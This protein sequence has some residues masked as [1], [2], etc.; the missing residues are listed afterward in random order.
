MNAGLLGFWLGGIVACV[1]YWNIESV[2]WPDHRYLWL[3]RNFPVVMVPLTVLAMVFW[4]AFMAAAYVKFRE[5]ARAD[6]GLEG[7]GSWPPE[8]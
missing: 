4:P 3:L 1:G 6:A 2:R 7:D 8:G 5:D